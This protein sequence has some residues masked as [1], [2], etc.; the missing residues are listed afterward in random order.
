METCN[1][2]LIFESVDKILW[3]DDHSNE[4]SLVLL[5]HGLVCFAGLEKNKIWGFS[6]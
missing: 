4:I 1:A 3:C 2:V 5:S 6:Q